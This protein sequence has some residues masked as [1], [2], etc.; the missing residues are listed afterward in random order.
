M[1]YEAGLLARAGVLILIGSAVGHAGIPEARGLF[2]AGQLERAEAMATE[3]VRQRPG[4]IE[5]REFL[6]DVLISRNRFDDAIQACEEA[7]SVLPGAARLRL[8]MARLYS[9]RQRFSDSVRAYDGCIAAKPPEP[10]C[11]VEKARVLGWAKRYDESLAQY[12]AALALGTVDW[13][14]P[15]MS[16]KE[17]LWDHRILEA[18]RLYVVAI[19]SRPDNGEALMDL[20][21]LYSN[22]G[23]YRAAEERY[24]RLLEVNPYHTAAMRSRAKNSIRRRDLHLSAGMSYWHAESS[25]RQVEVDRVTPFATAARRAA[26]DWTLSVTG[27]RGYY[28]FHAADAAVENGIGGEAAYSRGLRGGASAR[29]GWSGYEGFSRPRATYGVG[30]WVKAVER[31]DL[32]L[33]YSRENL[34]TNRANLADGLY[35]WSMGLR[36]TFDA[37]RHVLFG[38]DYKG[39][40]VS[41]HNPF[42]I[43]GAD[44]QITFL[45][46]PNRLYTI[47]RFETWN[48]AHDSSRYYAP[49]SYQTYSGL[50]GYKHNFG[51]EGL[52]YGVLE[53]YVDLQLRCARDSNGYGSVNPKIIAHADFSHRLYAEAAAAMTSSHYYRDRSVFA[54][55]GLYLGRP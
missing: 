53:R 35:Q 52:Y 1:R 43:A 2:A 3:L 19:S 39:G 15:E 10:D 31:V 11:W 17:A 50:L 48:Y 44:A 28:H 30:G 6:V 7:L 18:E 38:A 37:G 12:R 40:R 45:S 16:A 46:E 9:W 27:S 49:R 22:S 8:T 47:L 36:G 51:S 26:D 14:R 25:E 13:L 23:M 21:Q 54:V 24:A 5:S 32:S 55:V 20:A 4:D 29:L 34:N 42:G 41:D 33:A